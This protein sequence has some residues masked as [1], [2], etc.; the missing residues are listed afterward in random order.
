MIRLV[1]LD[2]D[3]TLIGEDRQI[4]PRV[5]RAIAAVQKRGVIVTLATGRMFAATLPFA[6]ELEI[7]APLLSYQ[8]GWIQYPADDHPLYRVPLHAEIART[9]LEMARR[10]HW[11]AVLYADGQIFLQ[12]FARAPEFYT[13]LLGTGYQLVASWEE[14]LATQQPDKV[15]LVAAPAAIPVIEEQLRAQ[16]AGEALVFRS[17]AQFVEVVPRGVDKGSGLAWLTQYLQISPQAV[18]AVGDQGNDTPM[19]KWARIGVA[20]GNAIPEVKA[21]ADWIA[22][23]LEEDGAAAALEHFILSREKSPWR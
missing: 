19:L 18:M 15:L 6:R 1:A 12:E 5:R 8:G 2:L 16:L 3:G 21:A 20:M 22:P 13:A 10:E 17:H 9:A 7:T 23:P 4:S 11:H 14:V